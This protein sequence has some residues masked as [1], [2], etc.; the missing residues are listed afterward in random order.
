MR[1]VVLGL[2]GVEALICLALLTYGFLPGAD[3]STAATSMIY[4]VISVPVIGGPALIAALLARANRLLWLGLVL[5][6]GPLV[7]VAF[8]FGAI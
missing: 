5:T 1:W 2:A 3:P 6:I 8:M 7:I 4:G